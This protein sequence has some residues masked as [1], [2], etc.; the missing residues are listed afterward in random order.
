MNMYI[1]THT[2]SLCCIAEIDRTLQIKYSGKNK[3]H[4]RLSGG[5]INGRFHNG[6]MDDM[7]P[8]KRLFYN[9]FRG[10]EVFKF[11]M[12]KMNRRVI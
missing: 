11:L 3:N 9:K 10:K 8:E 6:R 7:K 1:D 4:I 12:M 5:G 2:G